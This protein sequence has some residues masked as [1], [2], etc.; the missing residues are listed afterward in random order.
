MAGTAPDQRSERKPS[1][2]KAESNTARPRLQ[3]M[4]RSP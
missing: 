3:R 1:A 2:R 4:N